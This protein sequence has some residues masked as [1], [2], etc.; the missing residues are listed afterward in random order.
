M[1][2]QAHGVPINMPDWLLGRICMSAKEPSSRSEQILVVN[3]ASKT[4]DADGFR[5]VISTLT[6]DSLGDLPSGER[7]PIIHSV[8]SLEHLRDGHV[9]CLT[10]HSGGII[11]LY[12]PESR[13]NSLFI[14]DRCNSN[15]L[16]CSQ[17]PIDQ[18]DDGKF[19]VNRELL[20]LM[21]PKPEV[22]GI[23]GGEPTLHGELLLQLLDVLKKDF[24][25]TY[26]HMLTNGRT[27]ANLGYTAAFA[28]RRP[29]S[30]MLGIPLYSHVAHEHDYVVQAH[31]A[32]DQTIVG[33][34]NL[35]RFGQSLEVR[36]VIHSLTAPRLPDIAEFIYRNLPFVDHVAFMGLEMMGYVRKNYQ[37][38]WIDPADCQDELETAI[39]F[40]S[41]RGLSVSIYNHQL[42]LL[43]PSLWKFARQSISDWKNIY[44]DECASCG[45]REQCGGLFK[46][47]AKL[48]S[49]KIR[50]LEAN[51]E[52]GGV[53]ISHESLSK[54]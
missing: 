34:H 54:V 17:P 5:A 10:R 36:I 4:V 3:D 47:A 49:P 46:S 2:L 18:P 25:E 41:I 37:L 30:M 19:D 13:H 40:L 14:T 35:A 31:S 21:D 44:I 12:R 50:A 16:M 7:L 38:L 15:C 8:R 11:T 23:T 29:A 9:V 1:K 42:C 52:T 24:P 33:F 43:R 28:A 39:E 51:R 6:P 26:I 45:V 22:L 48:H 32:F 53:G 20:S 27:F